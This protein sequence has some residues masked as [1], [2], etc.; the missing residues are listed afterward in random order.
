[1]AENLLTLFKQEGWEIVSFSK[2]PEKIYIIHKCDKGDCLISIRLG[3]GILETECWSCKT[4]VPVDV[5][6]IREMHLV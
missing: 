3:E 6:T 4:P 5:A 1:M 2:Q